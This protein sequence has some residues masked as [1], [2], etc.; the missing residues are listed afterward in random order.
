MG[1]HYVNKNT[2]HC[3]RL[4][5]IVYDKCLKPKNTS[6]QLTGLSFDPPS[7]GRLRIS[8][9]EPYDRPIFNHTAMVDHSYK[10]RIQY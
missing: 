1:Y 9:L 5:I 3:P 4:Y 10:I 8:P 7:D 6:V 2:T